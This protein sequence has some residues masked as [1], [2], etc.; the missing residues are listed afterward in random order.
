M[1]P[2]AWSGYQA[3]VHVQESSAVKNALWALAALFRGRQKGRPRA[4]DSEMLRYAL[5]QLPRLFGEAGTEAEL[6][7]KLAAFAKEADLG[8]VEVI[9][10]S[11]AVAYRWARSPEALRRD[12]VT[13][14]FTCEDTGAG[15]AVCPVD[16]TV[17][18]DGSNQTVTG[19]ATASCIAFT[20]AATSCGSAIRQA[21]NA[22]CCT[23]SDGQ[24]QFR[25]ISS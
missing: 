13:A 4:R 20:H 12:S 5:P 25:L 23:R 16:Q 22:P 3:G 1:N 14:H 11:E 7:E 2:E 6:F 9:D 24:P 18:T 10:V 19:T 17:S 21:P 15:V 8:F